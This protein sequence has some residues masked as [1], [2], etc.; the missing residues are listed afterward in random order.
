LN[1]KLTYF[2][3]LLIAGAIMIVLLFPP[4]NNPLIV[5]T[6]P[7]KLVL[8]NNTADTLQYAIFEHNASR[9]TNWEPC[10]NPQLCFNPG[11]RPGA[12]QSI[13][14]LTIPRWY[15]GAEI[16]VYWWRLLPDSSAENGYSIDG[17][18]Q[19]TA[20]TPNKPLVGT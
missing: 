13:P 2:L 4:I 19:E 18:Y 11:I 7:S 16:V 15:P 1:Y 5:E 6:R 9:V 20:F 3:L 14:Y 8:F 17:P 12:A 10:D